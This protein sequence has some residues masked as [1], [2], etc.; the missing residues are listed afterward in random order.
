MAEQWWSKY[1]PTEYSFTEWRAEANRLYL[2][3][4]LNKDQ[5]QKKIGYPVDDEGNA[6]KTTNKGSRTKPN[7]DKRTGDRAGQ[8]SRR[9]SAAAEQTVGEDVYNKG[10]VASTGSGL[11]EHHKRVVGLYKPFFEG[12]NAAETKELAQWFV[13]EGAPLGNVEGNLTALTEQQHEAIHSWMK[14]NRMQVSS[15]K[16]P[17]FKGVPLNERFVAALTFLEQIQPAADEELAKI[18][19]PTA[20]E[21]MQE[22]TPEPR[23]VQPEMVEPQQSSPK[24][25]P[26]KVQEYMANRDMLTDTSVKPTKPVTIDPKLAARTLQ[27]DLFRLGSLVEELKVNMRTG[28][29]R[30]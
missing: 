19:A 25:E 13:D 22:V 11:Q 6:I 21:P 10:I 1:E 28:R 29:F 27:D 5:I 20:A 30:I 3:E 8:T 7:F 4:N 9:G 15:K 23:T 12:L 24:V 26:D 18:T 2:E 14:E 17:S 16:F